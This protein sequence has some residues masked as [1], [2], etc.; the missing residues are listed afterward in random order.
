M[1]AF[2]LIKFFKFSPI[3]ETWVPLSLK[4]AI[5][6]TFSPVSSAI[7]RFDLPYNLFK[8]LILFFTF[9]FTLLLF[10]P[11]VPAAASA[12]TAATASSN[13]IFIKS[14]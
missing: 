9:R 1:Y 10:V 8:L 4:I 12:L 5:E 6:P 14:R 11:K 13:D 7:D 2:S 3:E